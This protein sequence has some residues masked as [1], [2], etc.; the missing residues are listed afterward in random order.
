ME[1]EGGNL[2][3]GFCNAIGAP[4]EES[5]DN[6]FQPW[7][8][9][10]ESKVPKVPVPPGIDAWHTGKGDPWSNFK[11]PKPGEG[12][13]SVQPPTNASGGKGCFLCGGPHMARDCPKSKGKGA[14]TSAKGAAP[15][16]S[17]GGILDRRNDRPAGR[18]IPHRR[19]CFAFA[20][21]GH[22]DKGDACPFAHGAERR[23]DGHL[24]TLGHMGGEFE[25]PLYLDEYKTVSWDEENCCYALEVEQPEQIF[26]E[27]PPQQ[28]SGGS[29]GNL[30][31]NG[32]VHE[33]GC[34][35]LGWPHHGG[36]FACL[37]KSSPVAA[38]IAKQPILSGSNSPSLG[39][40]RSFNS[41]PAIP[42]DPMFRFGSHA[43]LTQPFADPKPLFPG[44]P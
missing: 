11:G 7:A 44:P 35:E 21:T 2:F 32:H 31:E 33:E 43:D 10:Q 18:R 37:E 9:P 15:G 28:E 5:D 25:P 42:A 14:P 22:C 16:K 1:I 12:L 17:G 29:V 13:A 26:A 19:L 8:S 36:L 41:A 20:R 38:H 40:P 3:D 27:E 30:G 34:E 4:D 6:I 23:K 39:S 24:Q